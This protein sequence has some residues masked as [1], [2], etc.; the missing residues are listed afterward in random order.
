M[1][2]KAAMKRPAAPAAPAP[3]KRRS[4][5]KV[6]PI[7][8]KCDSVASALL[9]A[10]G[11]PENV[12]EMLAGSLSS[13]LSLVKADRH[14]FQHRVVA[15]V[16]EALS[17]IGSSINQSIA[18]AE[19]EV[20]SADTNKA[21]LEA[22][23]QVAEKTLEA[24]K[25]AVSQ[26]KEFFEA[27]TTAKKHAT[28][29][30]K[31]AEKDEKTGNKELDDATGKKEEIDT[32]R[33][34]TY[35]ELT[36]SVATKANTKIL[37]TIGKNFTYDGELIKALTSAFAKA[38]DTR[39]TFDKLVVSQFEEQ[40]DKTQAGLIS[41]LQQ[42]EPGKQDRAAKVA[43]AT[44][45]LEVSEAADQACSQALA[46]ARTA[47]T[48]AQKELNSANCAL[49]AFTPA[50]EKTKARCE[51]LK[52]GLAEFAENAL[53]NFKEL[54]S[55]TIPPPEEEQPAAEAPAECDPLPAAEGVLAAA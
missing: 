35:K 26:K 31:D 52:A 1:A 42:G 3:A 20:A 15:M 17:E 19:T 41:V 5:G 45:S 8:Q 39:G 27:S 48:E 50:L 33:S 55:R 4:V 47:E 25:A 37:A 30:L 9:E 21:A 11:L 6:D 12:R 51:G 10:E 7:Q 43:A 28:A 32:F 16:G 23:T 49:A 38:P 18:E 54:E 24:R 53:A 44:S 29:A 2:P 36:E 40:M 22:A 13:C 34:I 46:D 14:N